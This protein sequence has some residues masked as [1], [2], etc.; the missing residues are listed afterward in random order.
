MWTAHIAWGTTR[1]RRRVEAAALGVLLVVSGYA[2]ATATASPGYAWVGWLA[3]LPLF[4]AIRAC[5]PLGAA[6]S[7]VVW[8]LA[9]YACSAGGTGPGIEPSVGSFALL[10]GLPALYALL[11]ALLARWIGFS[12][13]VLG[14]AW[15]GVELAL[16]PLGIRFGLLGATQGDTTLMHWVGGALGY[17][18]VAFVVAYV[19][20]ALLS[21][22]VHVRV[23]VQQWRPAT[24]PVDHGV[25]FAHRTLPVLVRFLIGPSQPRAP[26]LQA[27]FSA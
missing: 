16:E 4:L 27:L 20:A 14:V 9:F 6:L 13:L 17:V 26:P 25:R 24:N 2:M 1:T 3:L 18:L 11:T 19:S 15:M 8:G 10:A 22:V 21:V 23:L 12:P 7:G 5:R